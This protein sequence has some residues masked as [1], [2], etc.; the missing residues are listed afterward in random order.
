VA[1]AIR[2]L[3]KLATELVEVVVWV[4]LNV[5]LVVEVVTEVDVA[6]TVTVAVLVNEVVVF[7]SVRLVL[8]V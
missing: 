8:D 7:V 4:A 5:G 6:P 3:G 1:V 2:Q